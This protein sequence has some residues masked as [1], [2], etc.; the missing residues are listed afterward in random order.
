M[1]C[2]R[3]AVMCACRPNA[4][5]HAT[6]APVPRSVSEHGA[7]KLDH[8]ARA[9]LRTLHGLSFMLHASCL[10]FAPKP[11]KCRV[12]SAGNHLGLR[13][14]CAWLA[15]YRNTCLVWHQKGSGTQH[16][17]IHNERQ[18]SW[19]QISLNSVAE[20][21]LQM[22]MHSLE[23][24]TRLCAHGA[25]KGQGCLCSGTSTQLQPWQTTTL[26]TVRK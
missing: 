6:H 20:P 22:S 7:L 5:M 19:H 2:M 16:K 17:L 14:A 12:C 26:R 1:Q 11:H 9:C 10:S 24:A 13:S 15:L 18:C 4:C 3:V 21:V 8:C 23:S 25:Q